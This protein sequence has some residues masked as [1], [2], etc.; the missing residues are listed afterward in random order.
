MIKDIRNQ[1]RKGKRKQQ[2][3]ERKEASE[4]VGSV[5]IS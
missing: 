2:G 1:E 4:L 5:K 3:R